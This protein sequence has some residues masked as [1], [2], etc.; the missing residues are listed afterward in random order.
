MGKPGKWW[1]RESGSVEIQPAVTDI[2]PVASGPQ[3]MVTV[4]LWTLSWC[5]TVLPRDQHIRQWCTMFEA[6]TSAKN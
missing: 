3:E 2:G 4:R 5:P 6:E 1:E